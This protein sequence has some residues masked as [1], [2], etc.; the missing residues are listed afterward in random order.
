M[1][2]G[3]GPGAPA[4]SFVRE[5][6]GCMCVCVCV[7]ALH[8]ISTFPEMRSHIALLNLEWLTL[9]P[10]QCWDDR[11]APSYIALGKDVCGWV[12]WVG[13]VGGGLLI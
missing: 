4:L 1:E 13:G 10:Q 5:G 3:V 6:E 9:L 2:M 12:E 11:H 7:H 8:K